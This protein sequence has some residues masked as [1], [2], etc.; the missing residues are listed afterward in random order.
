[1]LVREQDPEVLYWLVGAFGFLKSDLATDQLI[2]LAHHPS[3]GV[4]YNVA[5]ALANRQSGALPVE[6]VN[7][8]IDLA[9]DENAEVRFSAAF[10]L[11]SWSKA[12][13]DPHIGS[14]LER[15]IAT[16]NDDTVVRAAKDSIEG[17]DS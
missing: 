12:D 13:H 16:D 8:L 17:A 14:V 9:E 10:E 5:T 4:R 11:G 7:A 15:V 6:S 1:M 3:S 2:S